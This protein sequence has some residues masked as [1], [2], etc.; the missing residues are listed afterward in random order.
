MVVVAIVVAA[1]VSAADLAAV[2]TA[3]ADRGCSGR[4]GSVTHSCSKNVEVAP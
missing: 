1:A 4:Y 2:A 3:E